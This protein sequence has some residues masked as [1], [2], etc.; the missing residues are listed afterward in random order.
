VAGAG[1]YEAKLLL[2]HGVASLEELA[3]AQDELLTAIPGIS[4]EGAQNVRQRASEL[5]AQKLEQQRLEAERAAEEAA[6][7]EAGA[8]PEGTTAGS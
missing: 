1:E 6:A 4:E 5:Q 8:V 3:V 2:D 7:T